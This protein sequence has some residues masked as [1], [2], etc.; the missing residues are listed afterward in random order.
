MRG[1][2]EEEEVGSMRR[3]RARSGLGLCQIVRRNADD[4][5]PAGAN[6]Q[7]IAQRQIV[8][9]EVHAIRADGQC[10]IEPVVHVQGHARRAASGQEERR[11]PPEVGRAH[12]LGPELQARGP[13]R[14]PRSGAPEQSARLLGCLAL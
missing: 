11:G 12:A 8:L 1:D 9:S 6:P 10:H 4:Q 2:Q 13:R 7:S 14:K 3:R 5:S